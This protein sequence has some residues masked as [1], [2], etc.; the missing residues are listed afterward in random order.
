MEPNGVKLSQNGTNMVPDWTQNAAKM[1][2]VLKP[3]PAEMKTNR[4][5]HRLK[6]E[7]KS[8]QNENKIEAIKP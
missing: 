2:Q 1:E 4:Q 8:S 3:N 5:K 7:P 6:R